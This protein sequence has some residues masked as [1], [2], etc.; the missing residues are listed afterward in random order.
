MAQAQAVPLVRINFATLEELSTVFGIGQTTGAFI[1]ALR[2]RLGNIDKQSFIDLMPI[3]ISPDLLARFDFLPNKIDSDYE[4]Y[5]DDSDLEGSVAKFRQFLEGAER[6]QRSTPMVLGG[7]T[8]L[9]KPSYPRRPLDAALQ[10]FHDKGEPSSPPID[11]KPGYTGEPSSPPI[12]IKPGY[13]GEP[14][15]PSTDLKPGDTGEPTSTPSD[16]LPGFTG[17]FPVFLWLLNPFTQGVSFFAF[18]Q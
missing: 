5:L 10:S 17:G 14:S 11:I 7:P 8:S 15:G 4:D 13:T 16:L 2:D 12:D 3:K 1:I 9:R 6:R 18:F